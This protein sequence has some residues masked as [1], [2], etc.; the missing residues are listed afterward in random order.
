[1]SAVCF[2]DTKLT[3]RGFR[4]MNSVP[5]TLASKGSNESLGKQLTDAARRIGTKSVERL[6]E[7]GVDEAVR[8]L[9][10]IVHT[11]LS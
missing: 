3:E 9:I 11:W 10:E 2:A 6:A 4:I 1:M 7:K 8:R 5:S